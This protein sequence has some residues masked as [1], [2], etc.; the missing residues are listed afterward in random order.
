LNAIMTAMAT[1]MSTRFSVDV[2]GAMPSGAM[3]NVRATLDLV[4]NKP[5]IVY[6]RIY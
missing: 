3:M 2:K 6:Y 5:Q 1:I 4:N